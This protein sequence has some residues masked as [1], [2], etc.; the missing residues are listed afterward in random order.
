MTEQQ[1]NSTNGGEDEKK[2]VAGFMQ[3]ARDQAHEASE[4]DVTKTAPFKAFEH[5]TESVA[6]NTMTE[7]RLFDV[8][9]A[10]SDYRL[11]DVD[12]TDTT[13]GYCAVG[14]RFDLHTKDG[15][16]LGARPTDPEK[17]P[18]NGISTCVKGKF[19]YNYVNSDD[20]LTEPLVKENGEFRE[21]SWDEALSRVVDGLGGII[22]EDSP[23][24]LGLISSSKAT[25]E[26]NYA[27]QRF[28][29]EVI[30]TNNVD[31]CNRLCHAPTVAAL[32][33]TVGYGAAS[34]GMDD[35][36]N[37]DCYL[38][39]GSNTTEAHPVLATRIKQNVADGADMVVFDPR[40]VQIAEY[41]DQ[42]T[43]TEPG[44]DTAWING[45]TRYIIENDLH[46]EE[47]I[48]ERTDGFDD[49]KEHLD[50]FTP[51]YVER[52]SGVPPEEL[53]SAAE[54]IAAADSCC[55][56]WT[57]GL[58][59][60]TNGTEN[61]ISMSNLALVTGNIGK[62]GAGLSPFRGQNNV[63]GGGGDMGPLPN[64]FPGYQPVTD[65]EIREK[66][67]AAYDTEIPSEE[68]WRT[69]EQFLAADRGDLRGM[70]IMGEN[71][72]LSEPGVDH[73]QEVLD[74]LDF[75]AVQDI[76]LTETAE[77]ADVVLPATTAV[78]SNGTFTSSSRH[79]QLVKRAIEPK[80]NTRG[81]WEILQAL[82]RRFG[83]D[84]DFASPSEIMDEIAE[85]TPIYGGISHERLE[86]GAELQWPCWD[87]GHPGTTRLYEEEFNTADGKASLIP[88]GPNEP[89]DL[90]D[91]EF[92]LTMTTGR[93][94]YQYH[95]GTMTHRE[96][97][98]M[99]YVGEDF[100]EI[101]PETAA[102]AGIANGDYVRVESRHGTIRVKAQV[103]ERPGQDT[104]FVPMH[105][106]ESAVN[107]LTDENDLD[108]AA[109]TP[110]YKVTSVRLRSGEESDPA[111]TTRE[112]GDRTLAESDD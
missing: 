6:L 26:D 110:E 98:I 10:L 43:R 20:R 58:T 56:C 1:T 74:D 76:F 5:A 78:E 102:N 63:Q 24:A 72:S 67:E 52:V 41:A 88:T 13:C 111:R 8:A 42:Y 32:K 51:K 105:F 11:Q 61:I 80:G 55:F 23:D 9:D 3:R 40:K 92:P 96:E 50:Q 35:L 71:A 66:F 94:L 21:A 69:T 30:G 87:D 100:V 15:E 68:G 104:V 38:L 70:Y 18:I 85:L 54:T 27:M 25:N 112:S 46:D 33:Q 16:V 79:V 84:W 73:A 34:V 45:L 89:A 14:C 57:L 37:T 36:E 31:N 49:L 91:D 86:N 101:N 75:L 12:V 7:G 99:S 65:D 4:K 28:A 47:F 90:S 81:D 39:S 83:H 19:S 2:G 82:A 59:E 53:A 109:R 22:E 17:A 108:T 97:G 44:Y 64:N 107:T 93:V 29:R 106:A 62:P 77:H 95:T 103:T 60:H 48:D